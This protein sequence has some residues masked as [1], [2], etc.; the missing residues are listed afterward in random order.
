MAGLSCVGHELIGRTSHFTARHLAPRL[1]VVAR[2]HDGACVP[3]VLFRIRVF[4]V[5][6]S[7]IHLAPRFGPDDLPGKR[8]VVGAVFV[9]CD[10]FFCHDVFSM[11]RLGALPDF[12]NEVMADV[13]SYAEPDDRR[14]QADDD[15]QFDG[16]KTFLLFH[17]A[18]LRVTNRRRNTR[19]TMR[20]APSRPQR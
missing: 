10:V 17:A 6:V 18:P 5:G 2:Q 9:C 11:R 20:R 16:G 8:N 15:K 1:S 12:G 7:V 3:V 13:N 4:L 19:R 14:S